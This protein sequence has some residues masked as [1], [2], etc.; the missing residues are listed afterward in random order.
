[1][2]LATVHD[3]IQSSGLGESNTFS[4]AASSKAFEILS[5]NLYQNK[6][7]AVVRE[8]SC[9]AADA[10]TSV[11]KS[12]DSIQVHLP[13]YGEPWFSVRDFGPGLSHNDVMQLYTT[14]F[15]STKDN[16]DALI[17]GFGLG[18]KSPFAVTDQFTV[19]SWHNGTKS[20]YVMYKDA[21]LPRVNVIRSVASTE[22]NGILVQV[23]VDRNFSTW[24]DEARN[25]FRWWSVRP[26]ITPSSIVIP[27][28]PIRNETNAKSPT[29][30]ANGDP[31]WLLTTVSQPTAFVGLVPYTIDFSAIPNNPHSDTNL[32]LLFV[33]DVGE[34]S[35]NPSRET[36]SYDSKTCATII[37]RLNLFFSEYLQTFQAELAAAPTLYDAR[38]LR[39]VKWAE[40]LNSID[41][42]SKQQF[43]WKNKKIE[44]RVSLDFSAAPLDK[45][46]TKNIEKHW[47][48]STWR[49]SNTSWKYMHH[50]ISY[51]HQRLD[52]VLYVWSEKLTA[53][54][55]RAIEHGA[56]TNYPDVTE[57]VITY[58]D[59][60]DFATLSKAAEEAGF[61]PI[62]D[63]TNWPVPPPQPSTKSKTPVAKG[64]KYDFAT[65]NW[66]RDLNDIDMKGGG[67]Y[68]EFFDGCPTKPLMEFTIARAA[69]FVDT[70][71]RFIGFRRIQLQS[72]KFKAELAANGWVAYDNAWWTNNVPT[73]KLEEYAYTRE[74]QERFDIVWGQRS[75]IETLI[76]GFKK[77]PNLQLASSANIITTLMQDFKYVSAASID[78]LNAI[79]SS[80]EHKQAMLR[81]TAKANRVKA[82][83][84]AFLAA[85][86]L[87]AALEWGNSALDFQAVAD[88][89][90]R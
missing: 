14:Y 69:K 17:G 5:S 23:G 64:Y 84:N 30:N 77:L 31:L 15:Q 36:L 63:V 71:S 9:N 43:S 89:I 46:N 44:S 65:G 21:G 90:N 49:K 70:P 66:D 1:M 80:D 60:S 24:V 54:T 26:T 37:A 12:F 55:Y 62:H 29:L 52:T 25:F 10:H 67:L 51:Y 42:S 82:D 18:S 28:Y 41:R 8:I 75:K 20:E 53:K 57:I 27:D 47:R 86:P 68:I 88:Y 56:A 48:K 74:L 79:C 38:V 58:G 50:A 19:T 13:T 2:R 87:C 85:H 73:N 3:P 78:T 40:T 45:Y 32:P 39:Y 33:F 34:V 83:W 35:I 6:I 59:G 11:G 76:A 7:L 22:P 16:S 4:I 61:P 81:A 72:Q